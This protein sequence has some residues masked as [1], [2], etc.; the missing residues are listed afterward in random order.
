MNAKLLQE[1]FSLLD[2]DVTC[3]ND[4][5]HY[6]E[7]VAATGTGRQANEYRLMA[8]VCR[9]SAQ[10]VSNALQPIRPCQDVGLPDVLS[11]N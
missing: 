6:F 9:D 2:T 7:N 1:A 10:L 5:A 11:A 8:A 3:W 4:A